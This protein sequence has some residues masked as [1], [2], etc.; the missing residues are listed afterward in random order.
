MPRGVYNRS[1]EKTAK[2]S[3]APKAVKT[4]KAAKAPMVSKAPKTAKVA[5]APKAAKVAKREAASTAFGATFDLQ[6]LGVF[7]SI[8]PGTQGSTAKLIASKIEAIVER[9]EP[10]PAKADVASVEEAPKKA[11]KAAAP[12]VFVAPTNGQA[13]FVPPSAQAAPAA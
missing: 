1:T 8:L 10:A 5:K 12:A 4:T 11:P 9:L 2:D 7:A 13:T 3:K 6:K